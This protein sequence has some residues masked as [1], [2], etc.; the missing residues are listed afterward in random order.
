[1][2]TLIYTYTSLKAKQQK[3]ANFESEISIQEPKIEMLCSSGQQLIKESPNLKAPIQSQTTNLTNQWNSLIA[4]TQFKSRCL[5]QAVEA[6]LFYRSLADLDLWLTEVE[7]E[8]YSKNFG[9]DLTSVQVL[10]RRII[11]MEQEWSAKRVRIEQIG[12]DLEK[13]S[14]EDHFDLENLTESGNVV[15]RRYWALEIPIGE[16]KKRLEEELKV[17][18]MRRMLE[19][20]DQWIKEKELALNARKQIPTSDY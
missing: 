1:M 12:K 9:R 10:I 19:D 13:M 18:E 4:A 16:R 6:Q 8:I 3:H 14:R 17:Y 15:I 11:D 7:H 2:P 20:E 5:K